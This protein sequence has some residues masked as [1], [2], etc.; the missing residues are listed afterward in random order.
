M[1]LPAGMIGRRFGYK[2]GI[3]V[4]LSLAVAGAFWFVHVTAVA[5]YGGFLLGLLVLASG[6]AC[7]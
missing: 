3:I 6:L 4:G 1:A 5:T 7:L 2:G